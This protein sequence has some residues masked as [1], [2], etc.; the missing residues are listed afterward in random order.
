MNKP[1]LFL[2][3]VCACTMMTAVSCSKSDTCDDTIVCNTTRPDSGYLNVKVTDPGST[4]MVPV[5]IYK[6]D[7]DKGEIVL[8][9]TMYSA[10]NAYLLPI[11]ER[12]SARA[13]YRSNGITTYVYDGDKIKI[14]KFWNCNDKCFESLDGNVNL[15]LK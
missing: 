15:E 3:A 2:A 4:G 7:V 5:T 13:A 8:E 12:Y 14:N 10:E 11:Q 6:G 9:D 1:V